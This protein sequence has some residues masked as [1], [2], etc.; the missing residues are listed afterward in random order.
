MCTMRRRP[1]SVDRGAMNDSETFTPSTV[2]TTPPLSRVTQL[3][4]ALSLFFG[5]ALIAVPQYVEYLR[6]GDL[7]RK[8]HIAW[9]LAHQSFYR[10]E[11]AAGMV[12]S[13]LLLLGFMGLWHLTRWHT[14]KLTVI[15]A[16]VLT[17]GMT[18]QIFSDVATYTAQV[19]AAD[20]F[21]ASG[22]ERL[23]ADGYMKD[24][25]MIAVV[26]VPVIAGMFFGVLMLAAACWR[27]DL[28]KAPVVALALWPLWDFFA[29]GPVGPFTADLLLLFSGVWLGVAVARQPRG[30]WQ[31]ET[32]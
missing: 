28:P 10:A 20:V 13:F 8:E 26:L 16:V 6:A 29:P 17:W 12:G 32:G 31:G 15:G 30:R 23:I 9:G 27:S 2:L 22:A 11:W 3:A 4:V 19:V 25:G 24:P 14:P 5:S 7:E 1:I 21:G 18:G